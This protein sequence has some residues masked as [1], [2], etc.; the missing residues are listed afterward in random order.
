MRQRTSVALLAL[1]MSAGAWGQDVSVY[2]TSMAQMWK[3]ETP[4]FDKATMAPFTQFVGIDATNLGTERLSFHLFGWGR[5][6]LADQ[7]A[8]QG[9]SGGKSSGDLSAGYLQ[10]RMPYANA[11]IKAGRLTVGSTS[12]VEHLDGVSAKADLRGGFTISAFGGQPVLYR[13]AL[14]TPAEKNDYEFQRNWIAGARLGLRIARFGEIGVSYLQDGQNAAKDLPI[15]STTDYTRRHLGVDLRISPAAAVDFNGRTVMDVAKHAATPAGQA[16]PSKVA[17][18]D[19][20]LALRMAE[21]WSLAGTF[22]ERNYRAYYA[23]TNVL[24]IFNPKEIGKFN[25][26]GAALTYGSAAAL[27]VVVDYKGTKRELTGK[28]NRIGADVRYAISGKHLATGFGFHKVS[29]DDVKTPLL[30]GTTVAYGL[31]HSEVR[32]WMMH[33]K[34]KMSLSLDGI[35]YTFDDKKNPNLNGKSSMFEVVGSLGYQATTN[36]KVSGDLSFGANPEVKKEVRGLLRAEYRFGG[37]KG[38]KK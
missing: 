12:G 22:T 13:N 30:G 26:Y 17:E 32:A 21:Q 1:L 11:E 20:A 2:G 8:Y 31:S 27:Q 5:A 16:E 10:Y 28:A 35:V 19:Y 6:D 15:P 25:A 7:S 34:G 33:E 29:A 4:G 36:V 3:S 18:H 9:L 37:A 24:S 23:G 38:G 14:R